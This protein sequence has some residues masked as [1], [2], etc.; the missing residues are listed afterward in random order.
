MNYPNEW[1]KPQPLKPYCLA[2]RITEA[3][4]EDLYNR[5]ITT[6]DLAKVLNVAERYLSN[7]FGGKIP[8]Y[9]KAI[10]IAARREF[11]IELA[12][13][14]LEGGY[15]TAQAA[16]IAYVSLNTMYRTLDK[17][18]L[19]YPALASEFEKRLTA[20]RKV[21]IKKA[22]DAKRTVRKSV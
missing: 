21:T 16:A 3:Q 5:R 14:V 11:R 2:S 18:K 12:K 15:T 13:K 10:L 8:I 22:R 19:K 7:M 17:A 1:P 9:N 20:I 6:R 4:K